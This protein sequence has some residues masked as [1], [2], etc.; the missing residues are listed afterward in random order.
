[1]SVKV[2]CG[3]NMPGIAGFAIAIDNLVSTS[4]GG[5]PSPNPCLWDKSFPQTDSTCKV[6]APG[7]TAYHRASATGGAHGLTAWKPYYGDADFCAAAQHLINA[8]LATGKDANC[9]LTGISSTAPFTTV[10]F[11]VRGD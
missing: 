3:S 2:Q 5:L 7:G 4:N 10:P 11:F 9:V 1:M 8:G 6:G